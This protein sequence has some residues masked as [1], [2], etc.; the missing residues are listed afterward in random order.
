[1]VNA[2]CAVDHPGVNGRT[3][4]RTVACLALSAGL[5]GCGLS[6]PAAAPA[7]AAPA[8]PSAHLLMRQLD[9]SVHTLGSFAMHERSRDGHKITVVTARV[10]SGT[11]AEFAYRKGAGAYTVRIIDSH[12]WG[13]ANYSFLAAHDSPQVAAGVAG[14]WIRSDRL[15]A[16][17]R[18]LQVAL[19]PSN[20]VYCGFTS[21][22][23]TLHV[24]GTAT[25]DGQP[26][27]VIAG[28]G[29]RPGTA[30][31]RL[32]VSQT[33]PRVPLRWVKDGRVKP[34][35]PAL[36]RC[37]ESAHDRSPATSDDRD[38]VDFTRFGDL[39]TITAPRHPLV[40][41]S[42]GASS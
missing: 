41:P 30:R 25:V 35:A 39:V 4:I 34:G 37:G 11:R 40:A 42:A 3:V 29:D 10:A 21:E 7:P 23:G 24:T 6:H 26:A 33:V 22:M 32:Y 38:A 12:S 2:R 8:L 1:M 16:K 9:H 19:R 31:S 13:R 5:A 27:Y 36:P 17:L 28:K 14:R 15:D 20:F 18:P